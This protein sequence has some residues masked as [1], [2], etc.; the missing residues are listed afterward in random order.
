MCISHSKKST[1]IVNGSE[2]KVKKIETEEKLETK[3]ERRE[4]EQKRDQHV[5]ASVKVLQKLKN[6]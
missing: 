3:F 4:S 1:S 5:K 2:I 6:V